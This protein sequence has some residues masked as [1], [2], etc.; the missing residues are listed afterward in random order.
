LLAEIFVPFAA[1]LIQLG[2]SRNREYLADETGAKIINDPRSLAK[3][4]A[5]LER[6]NSS[7]V[8]SYTLGDDA[9]T[10]PAND[11]DYAHMWIDEPI[12]KEG[13]MTRMF[14]THPPMAERIAR[15]NKLADEMK[16]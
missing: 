10:N 7:T 3:A 8:T 1:M 15:L 14:S 16:K 11:Y 13:L 5:H 6:G 9:K 4:L 2:I 12:K